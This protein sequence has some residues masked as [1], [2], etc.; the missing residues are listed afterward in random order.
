MKIFLTGS[1]G[2]VGF[3]IL[4]DLIKAGHAVRCLVRS[5]RFNKRT[6]SAQLE[7]VV[8]DVTRPDTLE[9]ALAGC[10]AVIHLVAII[11]ESRLRGITF[12][13]VNFTAT[14]NMIEAARSQGVSRFLHMSALGADPD[15]I[16]PYLRTKG[17]AEE[18]VRHSGLN[19]TIF[20]PSFIFGPGDAVYG[21][22]AKMIRQ[23]PLGIIPIFGSGDYKHQPISIHNV[24]QGFV[25]ALENPAAYNKTYDVG[26]PQALTYRQQLSVIG[27]VINKKVRPIPVPISIAR[28]IAFLMGWLPF[29]P[30]DSDRLKMLIQDNV[31]DPVPF[32]K[33]FGIE[34]IP[35]ERG[36]RESQIVGSS[37]T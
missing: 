6:E 30:I 2:Y 7:Y 18:Y 11:R 32:A 34:L 37:T 24:S 1:T 17:R 8:G 31:C 21:M 15:G 33:D 9:H 26:G 4:Q 36:F 3:F 20:R 23:S 14:K 27:K 25:Q 16:T 13:S 22:I 5:A 19:Y 29:S 12:E 28:G 10:D 35:F